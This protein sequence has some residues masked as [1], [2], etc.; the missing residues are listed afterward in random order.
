MRTSATSTA[1]DLAIDVN[2]LTP[3]PGDLVIFT[4]E[5][6]DYNQDLTTRDA[7]DKEIDSIANKYPGATFLVLP[8]GITVQTLP[9]SV[10]KSVLRRIAGK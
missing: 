6:S 2:L 3:K 5:K 9:E 1:K 7:F 10:A 8:K 4:V